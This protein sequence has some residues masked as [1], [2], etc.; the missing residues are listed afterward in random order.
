MTLLVDERQHIYN[1]SVNE[2]IDEMNM[3]ER[4]FFLLLLLFLYMLVSSV[5]IEKPIKHLL[6]H[7]N[8]IQRRFY[9]ICI[10]CIFCFTVDNLYL[11]LSL[12]FRSRFRTTST[13]TVRLPLMCKRFVECVKYRVLLEW[14]HV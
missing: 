4:T 13:I 8:V 6:S 9:T 3:H 1:I 14:T 10:F 11:F 12:S 5:F 7:F 2:Q